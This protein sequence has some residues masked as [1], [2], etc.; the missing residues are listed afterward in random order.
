MNEYKALLDEG[1]LIFRFFDEYVA[2]EADRLMVRVLRS[3]TI[4]ERYSIKII[5][6]DLC[7]VTSM[8][9]H[10]TD[11]ARVA[12]SNTQIL[13]LLERPGKDAIALMR[14]LEL[15][16]LKPKNE[17]VRDVW[18]ERLERIKRSN[19]TL[20]SV[21]PADVENLHDLLKCLGLL[22]LE[23]MLVGVWQTI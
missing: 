11:G 16:Y 7:D 6:W 2:D 13:S 3:M 21:G 9:L 20:P 19:R 18:V 23:P 4:D 10:A 12:N 14:N 5:I 1:V 17:L 15:F 8:T 22:K